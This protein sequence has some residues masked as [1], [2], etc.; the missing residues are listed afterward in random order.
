MSREASRSDR[1]SQTPNPLASR[2]QIAVWRRLL[3]P[4]A[5]L[6]AGC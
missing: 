1:E 4:T 2:L 5:A 3:Q 6:P